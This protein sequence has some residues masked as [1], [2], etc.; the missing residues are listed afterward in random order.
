MVLI[1]RGWGGLLIIFVPLLFIATGGIITSSLQL[2]ESFILAT[3]F[4][5][6]AAISV[7][8]YRLGKKW[9]STEDKV[10]I[11]KETNEEVV[12]K[13]K[14]KHSLFF[15]KMECWGILWGVVTGIYFLFLVLLA[16]T[17]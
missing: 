2:G 15:I 6:F 7:T 3:I 10:L 12:I 9:N 11:D 17:G 1:W 4:F 8:L 13:G 14:T 16:F 5:V